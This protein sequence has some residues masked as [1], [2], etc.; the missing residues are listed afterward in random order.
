M[1]GITPQRQHPSGYQQAEGIK[2]AK[3][4]LGTNLFSLKLAQRGIP[5]MKN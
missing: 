4:K 3:I 5:V 2:H 1:Q